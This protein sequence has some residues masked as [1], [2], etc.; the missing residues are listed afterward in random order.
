MNTFKGLVARAELSRSGSSQDGGLT[1]L[2]QPKASLHSFNQFWAS[3]EDSAE[4]NHFLAQLVRAVE[5]SQRGTLDHALGVTN[6]AI[7]AT[8]L[9]LVLYS[10]VTADVKEL[11]KKLTLDVTAMGKSKKASAAASKDP[12]TEALTCDAVLNMVGGANRPEEL[13]VMV[14]R[15]ANI[16]VASHLPMH[17]MAQYGEIASS[18]LFGYL[19]HRLGE[20]SGLGPV[21]STVR[22]ILSLGPTLIPP[23]KALALLHM[24]KGILRACH[25]F[26]DE[27]LA[28]VL[29]EVRAYVC[30]AHP[31]GAAAVDTLRTLSAELSMRVSSMYHVL[32]RECPWLVPTNGLVRAPH[33]DAA[34]SASFVV[35]VA[36][37]ETVDWA[38]AF[39]AILMQPRTR[40]EDAEAT[41]LALC[42]MLYALLK[43]AGLTVAAP[44]ITALPYRLL[45]ELTAEACALSADLGSEQDEPRPKPMAALQALKEGVDGGDAAPTGGGGLSA[46]ARRATE[47]TSDIRAPRLPPL[48]LR[49]LETRLPN[50]QAVTDLRAAAEQCDGRRYMFE[51]LLASL[52]EQLKEAQASGVGAPV[53][54]VC[55]AGG[56]GMLH[57]IVQ[58]YVVLRCAYPRLLA[59]SGQMRV[60]LLPFGRAHHNRLAAFIAARDGWY[61]RHVFAPHFAGAPTVPHLILPNSSS[62]SPREA[63]G[64]TIAAAGARTTGPPPT[65]PATPLRA[66][67]NDYLRSAT[68]SMPIRLFE[69]SCWLTPPA[70][71]GA[72]GSRANQKPAE[73]PFLTIAFAQSVELVAAAGAAEPL[74][75]G[76]GLPI[77]VSYTMADPWGVPYPTATTINARFS[78]LSMH[79][80]SLEPFHAPSSGRLQMRCTMAAKDKSTAAA[81]AAAARSPQ[82]HIVAAT[83][84]SGLDALGADGAQTP[85]TARGAEKFGLLVDGEYYGPF[86]HM[87]VRAC[88]VPG[89]SEPL[90][91]PIA[92][93]FRIGDDG[94]ADE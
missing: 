30:W 28:P 65:L 10:P 17:E 85:R 48:A 35:H 59:S 42:S 41:R 15:C 38:R 82:R 94:T 56:D 63:W 33:A 60:Y 25:A 20:Q 37:D 67:L 47:A 57:Q 62:S 1:L 18:L 8:M 3:L 70:D 76:A 55:V 68:A 13:R 40:E 4:A 24:L 9:V 31:V 90:T 22:G 45:L 87:Q 86:A 72:R 51:P 83:I 14:E 75:S 5:K 81:A 7:M 66:L 71:A 23:P 6:G 26:T 49:A 54:R 93:F 88:C 50:S 19:L 32:L 11:K 39:R 78:A 79:T 89:S 91:L 46:G 64:D 2:Q 84:T 21:I 16:T 43:G 52:H 58:A 27:E 92:T 73:P 80:F 44:K 77:A 61:R 12:P 53:L 29:K 36:I 69:V 34:L 74:A